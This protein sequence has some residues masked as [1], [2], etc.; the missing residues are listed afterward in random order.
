M[1][2]ATFVFLLVCCLLLAACSSRPASLATLTPGEPVSLTSPTAPIPTSTI[3]S[4]PLP[5][6][7][8]TALPTS[9]ET[10]VPFSPVISAQNASRLV[11]VG[12][13]GK[14]V[15]RQV[16]WSPSGDYLALATSIGVY[17]Y[18]V[19]PLLEVN[20]IDAPTGVNAVTYGADDS[21]LIAAVSTPD[22]TIKVINPLTGELLNQL[23]NQAALDL[24]YS[25]STNRLLSR[26][27]GD[28]VRLWDMDTGE[29]I[30]SFRPARQLDS[31]VISPDGN[32]VVTGSE[33]GY[34]DP[35]VLELWNAN[36]GA[37]N[38]SITGAVSGDPDHLAISP[39]GLYLAAAGFNVV[40]CSLPSGDYLFN[41][42]VND[43]VMDMIYSSDSMSLILGT[44]EGS[45][46]VWDAA[47]GALERSFTAHSQ[48][49]ISLASQP[50]G[51][52]VASAGY[53]GWLHLW[54]ATSWN[55][56]GAMG[57]FVSYRHLLLNPDGR[58]AAVIS[59]EKVYLW[60]IDT[61]ELVRELEVATKY[62]SALAFSPD[63]R[64]LA[65]GSC[66]T[67]E[68]YC[69]Y[70]AIELWDLESMTLVNTLFGHTEAINTLVF[71]ADSQMLAST[72]YG[73]DLIK[74][75]GISTGEVLQSINE[76]ITPEFIL[77]SPTGDRL[78]SSIM[79]GIYLRELP[80]GNIAQIVTLGRFW[81]VKCGFFSS[82]GLALV[83][84]EVGGE[85]RW[86]DTYSGI[87]LFHLDYPFPLPYYSASH[88]PY[89]SDLQMLPHGDLL[90]ASYSSGK[91]AFWDVNSRQMVYSIELPY[92][93]PSLELTPN[94]Y[95]LL[96]N[97]LDGII[98]IWG[99]EP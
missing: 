26:F 94:G 39:N 43:A 67:S 89:V 36:T 7:T 82:D 22:N 44:Y 47:S 50:N 57:G 18:S 46:Q 12:R 13:I 6:S 83:I 16:A 11:E 91:I 1:R 48:P 45:I 71:S 84:G 81:P 42:V 31:A 56:I 79:G 93:V 32:L 15:I 74:I 62:A 53:D 38:R 80:S 52:L 90:V 64:Y 51:S 95:Y 97:S 86:L 4:T 98:R 61:P 5:T 9:T 99:I 19:E 20:F 23:G 25:L 60:D 49:V 73:D 3:T 75:W 30:R 59:W 55:Q 27:A 70:G 78:A 58:L 35:R 72:S 63:N 28:T 41:G 37:L 69:P 29:S 40:V 8:A 10:P 76:S 24:S 65:V 96:T 33:V 2:K 17:V 14:G 21:I 87:E 66:G 85:I 77:L 34:Y 68:E 92:A 88:P 54:D